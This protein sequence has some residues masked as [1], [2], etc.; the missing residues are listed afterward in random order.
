MKNLVSALPGMRQSQ[1]D[2]QIFTMPVE[3]KKNFEE[4]IPLQVGDKQVVPD[5][6][7][8]PYHYKIYQIYDRKAFCTMSSLGKLIGYDIVS[9]QDYN[10]E[11]FIIP[12]PNM[13][14]FVQPE[15]PGGTIIA[16]TEEESR[17]IWDEMVETLEKK[18]SIPASA[19]NT[20]QL[21]KFNLKKSLQN[22]EMFLRREL[23]VIL[24][25]CKNADDV[26]S[27]VRTKDLSKK[28][29]VIQISLMNLK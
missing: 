15:L 13:A 2:G 18:K 4:V 24:K 6:N 9:L 10:G 23:S 14:C 20:E 19:D 25:S 3:V 5:K 17:H 16:M 22:E 8:V 11:Q 27:D 21:R 1:P 26:I 12:S 29:L 7:G 28:L